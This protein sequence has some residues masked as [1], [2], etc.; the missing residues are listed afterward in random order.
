[1]RKKRTL[2]NS[3][4][5]IINKL[6]TIFFV[7]LVRHF[8]A[9]YLSVE[10]LGY[11]G[12]FANILGLFSLVDLGLGNA[13]SFN[14][15]EPIHNKDRDT[16]SAIMVLYRKLYLLIG[17]VVFALALCFSPF[18]Q[19]FIKGN[20]LPYSEIRIYFLI[21]AFSV[22]VTYLFSYKRTMIFAMQKNYIVLN[23]DTI[24]KTVLSVLQIV[25]LIKFANYAYYLILVI[26]LNVIGNIVIS[27]LLDKEDQYDK[28]SKVK[29]S[30]EF[31]SKLKSHVKAL[32]ITNV[33]WQGISSTDN[34]IISSIVG[35]VELAKN[36]GYSTISTS[37]NSIV[38]TVLGGASA[39]IGDLLVEKDLLKTQNYFNRYCFVYSIVSS[40]AA[41]GV[42]FISQ[43]VITIWVGGDLVFE[44]TTVFLISLNILLTL[45]FRPL[46]DF[47]NY[48]GNFVYYKPYSIVAVFINLIISVVLG[49][50][51]GIAGVFIGTSVTYIFMIVAVISI[52]SKRLLKKGV[53]E[54]FVHEF[55]WLCPTIIS[56]FILTFL[57][58]ALSGSSLFLIVMTFFI[59]TIVYGLIVAALL[60]RTVEFK[61]FMVLVIKILTNRSI[62]D[63]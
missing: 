6:V 54:Y 22:A 17:F 47:Q 31:I 57:L 39:S 40:Y 43:P 9:K 1:M 36:A 38:S 14:L 25:V 46:S 26:V 2:L 55:I 13:I 42:Y 59:L 50:A 56:F 4:S 58:N 27:R 61:Y 21:Y 35:V 33:A 11:E 23:V 34:I 30:A 24:T 8:F 45:N 51:V 44:R 15:Y 48:S 7:F 3:I 5:G 12:L 53:K 10:Y 19:F 29:L 18:L 49:K 20:E 62:K 52:L 63:L 28:E 60:H 16:I 32:A 41:L 37:I